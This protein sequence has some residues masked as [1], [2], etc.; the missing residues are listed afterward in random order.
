M[1]QA[2][3]GN[4]AFFASNTPAWHGQGKILKD[5]PSPYEAWRMAYPF[6]VFE[7]E[8]NATVEGMTIP[9]PAYKAIARYNPEDP[10]DTPKIQAFT[11]NGMD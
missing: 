4:Y 3:E 6:E 7:L 10:S 1:A 5:A 9:A 2:I 8:V 11:R